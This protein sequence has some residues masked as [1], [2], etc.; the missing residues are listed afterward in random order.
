MDIRPPSDQELDELPHTMI[1]ADNYWDP[2][3]LDYEHEVEDGF[4]LPFPVTDFVLDKH[5]DSSGFYIH[6]H[7]SSS[8]DDPDFEDDT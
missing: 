3:D 8:P 6:Q 2:S 7:I 5:F 1:T 4:A